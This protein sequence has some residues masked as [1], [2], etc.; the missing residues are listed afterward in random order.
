MPC[1][2]AP[3]YFFFLLILPHYLTF[4][5]MLFHRSTKNDHVKSNLTSLL[6]HI[7]TFGKLELKDFKPLITTKEFKICEDFKS[8]QKIWYPLTLDVF[9]SFLF[10]I[11]FF[12]FHIFAFFTTAF[13]A[14]LISSLIVFRKRS[15]LGQM[16]LLRRIKRPLFQ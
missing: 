11:S 6:Q 13:S 14:L 4:Y 10:T 12:A 15:L 9:V 2:F 16:R 3:L 5:S 7:C 1:S 8:R